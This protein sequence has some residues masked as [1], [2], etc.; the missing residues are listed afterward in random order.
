[1]DRAIGGEGDVDGR[2]AEGWRRAVSSPPNGHDNQLSE[3]VIDEH[4]NVCGYYFGW[5]RGENAN[6]AKQ[7]PSVKDGRQPLHVNAFYSP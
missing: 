1:M 2:L 7:G 5:L 6:V 3:T 4:G